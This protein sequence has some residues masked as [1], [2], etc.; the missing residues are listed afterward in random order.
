MKNVKKA[1]KPLCFFGALLVCLLAVSSGDKMVN[2]RASVTEKDVTRDAV[3]VVSDMD[4]RINARI[5][6]L[7]KVY[8]LPMD[9]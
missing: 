9:F 8:V 3:R 7:P 4:S 2:D 1:G 5:F 6:N